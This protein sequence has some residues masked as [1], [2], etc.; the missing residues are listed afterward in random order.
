[1]TNQ[2]PWESAQTHTWGQDMKRGEWPTPRT[3]E[4]PN[5]PWPSPNNLMLAALLHDARS[6]LASGMSV[7]A[8]LLQLATHSWFEG[9]LDGYDTGQHDARRTM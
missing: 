1:M 6:S 7:E 8:V 9:G 2:D 4:M 5:P 3:A